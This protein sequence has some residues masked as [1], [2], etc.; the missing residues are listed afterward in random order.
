MQALNSQQKVMNTDGNLGELIMKTLRYTLFAAAALVAMACVKEEAPALNDN[1][2]TEES[3]A[4]D[5]ETN[6]EQGSE[7]SLVPMTFTASGDT[8]SD[9]KITYT[10]D[11]IT[12][13]EEGDKIMVISSNGTAQEFTATAVDGQNATFEGVQEFAESY[14]AVYPVSAYKGNDL[15]EP[16]NSAKGGRLYVEIPA[17]QNAVAGA[18]DPEAFVSIAENEGHHLAFKNLC[19]VVKFSLENTTGV[20]SIHFT[21]NGNTNLAGN[22]NV[23][24]SN[25]LKHEWNDSF[26]GRSS[27]NM[28]TLT[29]PQG[30]FVAG[31]D[32]YFTL[33]AFTQ[34]STDPVEKIGVNFYVK[35]NDNVK[36]RTGKSAFAAARNTITPIG[37]ITAATL[38]EANTYD[39][40]KNGFGINIAGTKYS[41]SDLNNL[42]AKLI[43]TD[44][45][46]KTITSGLY[47]ID[48]EVTDLKLSAT[49]L[50]QNTYII[51]NGKNRTH[52]SIKG[53]VQWKANTYVFKNLTLDDNFDGDLFKPNSA[54]GTVIFDNCALTTDTE[55]SQLIYSNTSINSL[56]FCNCDIKVTGSAKQL[57]KMGGAGSIQNLNITNNIFF[58]SIAEGYQKFEVCLYGTI[59]NLTLN[60][61]TFAEVY[62]VYNGGTNYY[63][64]N[65]A[66][67]SSLQMNNNLF[68][69]TKYAEETYGKGNYSSVICAS[70]TYPTEGSVNDNVIQWTKTDTRLKISATELTFG[71]QKN[72]S[73]ATANLVDDTTLNITAGVVVPI[74]KYG[75]TR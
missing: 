21:M 44:T 3:P 33:R 62:N 18:W 31:T 5:Q 71:P 26:T 13:W 2:A 15:A 10:E 67:L 35:Y 60:N 6:D 56:T 61:N 51:G 63:Y 72:C 37:T 58:P 36:V 12:A 69:L 8:D 29:A 19:S 11:K 68:Y 65:I 22:E 30:G 9:T 43:T 28:I 42:Q 64:F 57:I 74:N 23:Y 1:P 45:D 4:V 55:K 20:E 17:V 41:A 59:T 66:A 24:V 47:F 53:T 27:S 46:D 7:T 25:I 40:Y 75:A 32:Y 39:A 48:D 34:K 49:T 73:S 52:L 14:Y 16:T 50:D 38:R 54:D 70:T